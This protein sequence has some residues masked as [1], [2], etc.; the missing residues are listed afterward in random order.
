M[1]VIGSLFSLSHSL[2]F[3][4]AGLFGIGFIIGF[5][6]FGHFLFCKLFKVRTPSFSIGFGPRIISK[7]IGG[8]DF[9]LSAIPLGGYV[10]IAG[11]S[12]VG[13]GDQ[14]EAHARDEHSFAAKPWYQKFIIMFGGILFNVMFAYFA[15]SLLFLMG[16]PKSMLLYPQNATPVL[17]V[18]APNSPAEQ[19]G[20]KVGDKLIWA[21]GHPVLQA[22]IKDHIRNFQQS[23]GEQMALRIER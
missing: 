13:Q 7:K 12:E 10:E 5:H 11:A 23:P 20:L 3:G 22:T 9:A 2:F 14:K 6:E 18:V 21:Q 8:T 17:A 15:F 1:N 19:A 4:I 16:M